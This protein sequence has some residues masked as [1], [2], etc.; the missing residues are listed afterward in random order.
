VQAVLSG[1]AGRVPADEEDA[2]VTAQVPPDGP[3]RLGSVQLPDGRQLSDCYTDTPLPLLWATNKPLTDAPR[4][5]QMLTGMHRDTGLVPILLAFLG[6]DH[7][8]RPW[9]E[10]EL[11]ARCDL[12]TVD[13]LDATSVLAEAW[14]GK[15]PSRKEFRSRS[16]V[17]VPV[18]RHNELACPPP[19][20]RN[21]AV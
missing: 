20:Q 10:G 2:M 13:Q 15:A 8:G 19:V 12:A 18:H 4:V 6:D 1:L 14:A 21:H 5:W 17:S 7:E 3:V 11:D 16:P 9:D